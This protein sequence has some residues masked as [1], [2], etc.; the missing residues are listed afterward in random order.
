MHT[1]RGA[2]CAGWPRDW[3]RRAG[4]TQHACRSDRAML[5]RL[6]LAS[7]S[8]VSGRLPV[9]QI[10]SGQHPIARL[11][12]PSSGGQASCGSASAMC[13]AAGR[14]ASSRSVVRQNPGWR[15]APK[16]K[17]Q[18]AT[19]SPEQE[20][21]PASEPEEA[22]EKKPKKRATKPK[23]PERGK[24]ARR[25]EHVHALRRLTAC[26]TAE[27][28]KVDMRPE[29]LTQGGFTILSWNVASLRTMLAGNKTG[30]VTLPTQ[31][32]AFHQICRA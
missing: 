6:L 12:Q 21:E 3:A 2:A 22:E 17:K 23:A 24:R 1:P 20:A 8:L 15:R 27:H 30:Q 16:R 31:L 11:R 10:T 26:P 28:Y 9:A 14:A 4:H 5:R 13:A 32:A 18:A 7:H 19:A 25:C 29:R